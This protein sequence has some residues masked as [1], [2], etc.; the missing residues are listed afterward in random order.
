MEVGGRL[1][2]PAAQ[3][4]VVTGNE[5]GGWAPEPVWTWWRRKKKLF[6]AGNLTP[7]AHP[8]TYSLYWGNYTDSPHVVSFCM[9]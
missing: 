9:L 2:D 8:I 1:H 6:F 5:P 7:V 4:P 3:P